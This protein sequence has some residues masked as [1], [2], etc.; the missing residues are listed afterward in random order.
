MI[1][2]HLIGLLGSILLS[3]ALATSGAA[4]DLGRR[5]LLGIT[6]EPM[7]AGADSIGQGL[8]AERVVEGSAAAKAGVVAGDV[9]VSV[10]GKPLASRRR[11][12]TGSTGASRR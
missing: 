8:L 2:K 3:L 9:V 1:G 7:P 4:L 12:S 10:D 6:A 5:P 11:S